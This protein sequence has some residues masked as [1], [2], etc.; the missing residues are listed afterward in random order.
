M[1]ARNIPVDDIV[2][3]TELSKEKVLKLNTEVENT[4]RLAT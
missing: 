4:Q 1:L 2:A 3:I